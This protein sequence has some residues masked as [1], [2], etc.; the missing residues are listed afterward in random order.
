MDTNRD[1]IRKRRWRNRRNYHHA[2][3][4][5][6]RSL[7]LWTKAEDELRKYDASTR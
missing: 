2:V 1:N 6:E 7:I 3:E 4:Q 5:A